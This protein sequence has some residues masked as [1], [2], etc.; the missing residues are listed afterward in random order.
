[1]FIKGEPCACGRTR[2]KAG[3]RPAHGA[4]CPPRPKK[5]LDKNTKCV[6][7]K[8][9]FMVNHKGKKDYTHSAVVKARCA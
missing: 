1:M 8:Y 7:T 2:G 3:K 4:R 9:P 5:S 6:L